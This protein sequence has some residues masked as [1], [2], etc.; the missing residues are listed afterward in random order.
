MKGKQVVGIVFGLILIFFGIG[1]YFS[2]EAASQTSEGRIAIGFAIILGLLAIL[3]A[4]SGQEKK[5]ETAP[6]ASSTTVAKT[7][8]QTVPA[9]KGPFCTSC[10]KQVESDFVSCPYCGNP[11]KKKCPSCGKQ[12]LPDYVVCPFCGVSVKGSGGDALPPPPD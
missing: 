12:I 6:Q 11:L 2:D 8:A 1:A 3:G 10:G 4:V 7:T 5:P 9:S